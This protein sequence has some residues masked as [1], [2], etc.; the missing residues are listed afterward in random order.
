MLTLLLVVYSAAVV[1]L[2][3]PLGWVLGVCVVATLLWRRGRHSIAYGSARWADPADIPHLFEGSGLILGHIGGRASKP[4]AVRAL[5]SLRLPAR[6]ACRRFLSAFGRGRPT[7]RL[8]NAVHT[9]VFAPTGAGKGVSCVIPYL[10][11]CPDS[12]VVVDFKGENAALTAEARRRMGHQVVLLDPYKQVTQR[13]HTFNPIQ[14]LDRDS[15]TV[16]DDCRDLAEALAVTTGQERDPHWHQSAE[17]FIAAMIAAVV[18][19]AEGDDKSLQTV[20]TLLA[21]PGQ[22]QTAIEFMCKSDAMGGMLARLGH[23]LTHF[24]DKEL[25]STLTTANR[26]LRFLDTTAVAE[27]TGRSTFDPADLVKKKTT[28]KN[29]F[30]NQR[31]FLKP[32]RNPLKKPMKH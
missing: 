6:E 15:R 19:I 13:P 7:V 27:S 28:V 30:Q 1:V 32:N 29:I 18:T 14:S 3:V 31:K 25:A 20:R 10:L 26:F 8:S 22:M 11:T 24:K 17:V 23:Q 5:L 21:D 16:M 12:M 9:A 4:R 2:F